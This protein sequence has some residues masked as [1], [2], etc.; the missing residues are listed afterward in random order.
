MTAYRRQRLLLFLN[1]QPQI[2]IAELSEIL[3]VS[4]RTLRSDLK[5]LAAAGQS[6]RIHGDEVFFEKPGTLPSESPFTLQARINGHAKRSIARWAAGLVKDGDTIL[7]DASTTVYH[8]APFLAERRNL[9]VLT[10]GIEVGRCLAENTSN[11]V[12]LVAGVIRPDGAS[13]TGPIYDPI[14]RNYHI[15]TAFVSCAGFSLAAGLTEINI[16]EASVK[17]KMVSSAESIVALIDSTKFGRVHQTPFARADQVTHIFSDCSLEPHWIEQVQ[18]SSI[19][20]TLC[21]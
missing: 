17:S 16:N 4:P 19:V 21:Q 6:I 20:L 14:L 5:A 10:S 12:I 15:K 8:M 1:K 11:L 13:V 2:S 18:Q 9:V 7:M 3:A